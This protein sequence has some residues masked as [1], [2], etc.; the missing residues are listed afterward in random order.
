MRMR[1]CIRRR[2][3]FCARSWLARPAEDVPACAAHDIHERAIVFAR[4]NLSSD[5][6]T[7]RS[8][9]MAIDAS[10]GVLALL[11]HL[12]VTRKDIP[13]P[14]AANKSTILRRKMA[15]R[16]WALRLCPLVVPISPSPATTQTHKQRS[17]LSVVILNSIVFEIDEQ[18]TLYVFTHGHVFSSQYAAVLLSHDDAFVL[19][20]LLEAILRLS[21]PFR[22]FSFASGENTMNVKNLRLFI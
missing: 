10:L 18:R 9:M 14:Q 1:A 20:L 11:L 8:R 22:P 6:S 5:R 19:G 15:G 2:G 21:A 4:Q 3:T 12:G 13:S 16:T 17:P 7:K